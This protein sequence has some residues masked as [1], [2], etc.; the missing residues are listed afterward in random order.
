MDQ[1]IE[2]LEGLLIEVHDR[3]S[4]RK[5]ALPRGP[6]ATARFTGHLIGC[7]MR[8]VLS[9]KS[10]QNRD[11]TAEWEGWRHRTR[12]QQT[13]Q[14]EEGRRFHRLRESAKGPKPGST[15]GRQ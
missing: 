6:I 13:P 11:L 7:G 12:L 3:S 5:V 8:H 9:I 10:P 2:V 14:P 15:R 1:F 4:S